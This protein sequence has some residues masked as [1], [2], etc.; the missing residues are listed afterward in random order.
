MEMGAAAVL[1]N[2]AIA[3][4]PNPVAMAEAMNLATQAGRKAYL[5]GRM[6]QKAYASASSPLTGLVQ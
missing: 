3:L 6:P 1:I 2:S 5:A 4:S